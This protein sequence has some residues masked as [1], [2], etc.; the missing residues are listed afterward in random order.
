V[1]SIIDPDA[2]GRAGWSAGS[3]DGHRI[4]EPRSLQIALV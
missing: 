1:M 2:Q 4:G 3:G